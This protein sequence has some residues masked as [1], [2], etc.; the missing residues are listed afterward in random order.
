MGVRT[1][2]S[3]SRQFSNKLSSPPIPTPKNPMVSKMS[4]TIKTRLCMISD[5]HGHAP[6][7]ENRKSFAY[8]EPLPKADILL[9]AGDITMIGRLRE[10]EKMIEVLS[11]ADAE[12]KIVIAGNHDITLDEEYYR[13][14]G[15]ERFHDYKAEDLI[16]VKELWTGK[17]ARQAN[18]V[19]VE[20]G[21]RSF[22]LSSGTRF[23]VSCLLII[24]AF[25]LCCFHQDSSVNHPFRDVSSANYGP[26]YN[27]STNHSFCY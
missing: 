15:Q 19:Y 3:S 24:G 10:Y 14:T 4:Q 21:V 17:K 20:E 27:Q 18:I 25:S 23:T 8:R 6:L 7:P 26:C 1:L 5:T 12:L 11:K 16:A 22:S 13:E 2:F 9:H